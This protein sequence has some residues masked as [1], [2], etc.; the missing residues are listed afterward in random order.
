MDCIE[1]AEV[2]TSLCRK[3]EFVFHLVV[4]IGT[5]AREKYIEDNNKTTATRLQPLCR[6]A[7][8]KNLKPVK[9]HVAP[10]D[11]NSLILNPDARSVCALYASLAMLPR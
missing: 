9:S 7:K 11:R 2:E 8:S 1:R 4:Y 6:I 5:T 10:L 3:V